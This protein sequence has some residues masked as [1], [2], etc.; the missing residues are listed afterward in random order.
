MIA[1]AAESNPTVFSPTP[2][3]HVD[4]TLIPPYVRL[5]KWLNN[6]WSNT[7]FCI[8]Q[9]KSSHPGVS[10]AEYMRRSEMVRVAKSY[11][12]MDEYVEKQWD[13]EA[14]FRDIETTIAERSQMNWVSKLNVERP[15]QGDVATLTRVD[16]GS[17]EDPEMT[18]PEPDLPSEDSSSSLPATPPEPRPNPEPVD[19]WAPRP[20]EGNPIPA[21]VAGKDEPTPTPGGGVDDTVVA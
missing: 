18:A 13:G 15:A 16:G 4:R 21:F 11:E 19:L 3:D 8:R 2:L 17:V 5:S 12:D 14:V 9:F 6:H 7:A 1:T 10:K 20:S